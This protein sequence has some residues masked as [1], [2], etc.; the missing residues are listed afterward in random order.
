MSIPR[1]RD[2]PSCG[3]GRCG[4]STVE[5]EEA[6]AAWRAADAETRALAIALLRQDAA[7]AG[8]RVPPITPRLCRQG[9]Q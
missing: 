7:R 6:I 8:W 5:Y 3:A 1:R 2:P 9:A 4:M